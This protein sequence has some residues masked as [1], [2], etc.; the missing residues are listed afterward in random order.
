MADAGR[1]EGR[2]GSDRRDPCR[3]CPA[4][5]ARRRGAA[6]SN[7]RVSRRSLAATLGV[8]LLLAG[9]AVLR[10][11]VPRVPSSAIAPGDHT[12]LGRVFGA[13][14]V[15]HTGHS[16]FQVVTSAQAAFAS[17][18]A[19]ADTAERTLDLQYYSAGDDLTSNLLLQRVVL[20]AERGVRVRVLLDDVH[21]TTRAFARRAA[22]AHPGIQVRLF[23]PFFFGGTWSV[24]RLVEFMF[25][26]DRLNRRM[27]NKLWVTDNAVAMVG[28]RNLGDE[29]FG[30]HESA[31]FNDVDLLAVGP[32]VQE[33]SR[34]F[35]TYWNSA[36]AVPLEAVVVAPDVDE[37][38]R[39]RQ[40]L[41]ARAQACDGAP[42]CQWIAAGGLVGA[43]RSGSVALTW[44]HAQAIYD[45]PDLDKAAVASGIEHGMRDDQPSGSSTQRE[46]LIVSPYFIPEQ[47]GRDHLADMVERGVRVAVL[48]NS[49]ASTDSAAA[50]AGYARHR[51]ELLRS[52]VELFEAR[53]EP[54][55]SH[56]R[57][58]RW[59]RASPSSLHAKI[60]VQ[61]R[62]R[63]IVGSLN[64]DPRSRL[65]NTE[66][67]IAVESPELAAD[68]AELFE[69]A[70]DL[71]HAFKLELEGD[72]IAWKTESDEGISRY[73][74]EPSTS[75]WLR[76][77]RKTLG[78][79]I[80]EHQL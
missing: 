11:A 77:W 79:L 14:A 20:A 64:Q 67:W 68:L 44:A 51:V 24:S 2:A 41:Q 58:H 69:E 48:T 23:N 8:A 7:S 80:P 70:S 78:A 9:C 55:I 29:Y 61:D 54:S 19:L 27:H 6:R 72:R 3:V 57:L 31:N 36:A 18:A 4:R 46:L 73:D 15:E 71:H 16:G 60:V 38:D 53:P 22:A 74:V 52:G 34:A 35:D 1:R 17:R 56:R 45:H 66:G 43:L 37:G 21:A 63:A 65:H 62:T 32:I 42:P 59:G 30:V 26:G 49:L 76:A 39:L 12:T 13:Q 33:L 47:D 10:P 75:V 25:D 28:S 5:S 50:H 40:G